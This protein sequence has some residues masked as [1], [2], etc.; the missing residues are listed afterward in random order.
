MRSG[1]TIKT[2]R[3]GKKIT[4]ICPDCG[5]REKKQIINI[6]NCRSIGCSCGDG[7]SYPEK[8]VRNLLEQLKVDFEI[9]YS[10]KWADNKRY[11][12]YLPEHSCIVE[13]HG[14][15]HYKG[16]FTALGGRTLEEERANDEFKK[17]IAIKNGVKYYIILDCRKNDL[18]WMINMVLN[19]ELANLFDLSKIDWKKCAEFANKNIVKKVCE[20]WN[21]KRED[22]TTKDLGEKFKLNC[23]TIRN[24]LKKGSELGWCNYNPKDKNNY[25]NKG[26]YGKKIKMFKGE[27]LLG[28]FNSYTE[29]ERKSE[30]LFGVK[31]IKQGISLVCLGKKNQYK[32][33]SFKCVENDGFIS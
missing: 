30:S 26:R 25:H 19:S 28:E 32:G 14:E 20:Y 31:L 27:Q 33:F 23:Q 11:D 9:E 2:L 17:E 29:L 18:K 21:N 10:P 6:Y 15:Q 5:R 1:C 7:K 3:S 13:V 22:E 16:N 12:F 8:F 24:Y 4:V